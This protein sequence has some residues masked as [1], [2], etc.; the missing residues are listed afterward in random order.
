[1]T[2][3]TESNESIPS[4]VCQVGLGAQRQSVKVT[5]PTISYRNHHPRRH[6]ADMD[7]ARSSLFGLKDD[8]KH[9]L[10]RN[11]RKADKTWPD[12]RGERSYSPGPP[13]RPESQVIADSD[14]ERRGNI[15]S[16]GIENPGPSA[17]PDENR[18]EWK[19][20]VSASAK[21]LLRGV[22]DSADAFGPLK[23]IAG[24]LCFILENCEASPP[25]ICCSQRLS[26]PQRTKANKRAIE[27]R[28]L[29]SGS[30]SPFLWVTPRSEKGE[31]DLSSK[32]ILC[33]DET[34]NLTCVNGQEFV[35]HP[36]GP[37]PAGKTRNDRGVLQKH[38]EFRKT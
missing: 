1:M 5:R 34:Q 36:Q 9:L 18:S 8:F 14:R 15:S 11:K 29:P 19:S 23:S 7:N 25:F 31:A 2:L 10:E 6:H 4:G 28:R 16:I 20:T 22:R 21:L 12:G 24:G 30:A 37:T 35:P 32:S 38:R 3:S 26:V 17:A 27:S 33:K 13:A